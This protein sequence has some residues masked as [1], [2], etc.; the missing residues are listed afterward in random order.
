[1]IDFTTPSTPPEFDVEKEFL[2]VSI[3][4][5]QSKVNCPAMRA[6]K[7]LAK[8]GFRAF[9]EMQLG[10]SSICLARNAQ[11][12]DGLCQPFTSML[13]IDDDIE[14]TAD[15]LL[16]AWQWNTIYPVVGGGYM[17]RALSNPAFQIDAVETN[18]LQVTEDKLIKA[19][20]LGTGFLCVRREWIEQLCKPADVYYRDR[21][22]E[23]MYFAIDSEGEAI[24]STTHKEF[25]SNWLK[26]D[27]PDCTL[28]RA[29]TN[30]TVS[31]QAPKPQVMGYKEGNEVHCRKIQEELELY[32]RLDMP[33]PDRD[34]AK[35]W[36]IFED[37]VTVG[38]DGIPAY[39]TEDYTF[40]RKLRELGATIWIDPFI[41]LTHGD[42]S[43]DL[44][45]HASKETIRVI[46]RPKE[47]QE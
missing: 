28:Y 21:P 19:K 16:R 35:A 37:S 4:S 9:G 23:F 7:E 32:F 25:F 10:S 5:Y 34:L 1:M 8:R 6:V 27:A 40:C 17:C 26:S 42:K 13:F 39:C 14:C 46:E 41:K 18:T 22:T 29:R 20:S 36:R 38:E 15:D 2:L 44:T 3:P 43:V 11:V 31:L 30:P 12:S 24:Y 45:E 47:C 33:T